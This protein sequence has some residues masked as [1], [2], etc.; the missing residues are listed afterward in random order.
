MIVF[1]AHEMYYD[2]IWYDSKEN[3][4]QWVENLCRWQRHPIETRKKFKPVYYYLLSFSANYTWCLSSEQS[5]SWRQQVWYHFAFEYSRLGFDPWFLNKN[6]CL[7]WRLKTKVTKNK[8]T[9]GLLQFKYPL[10][11]IFLD[12][13]KKSSTHR[14]V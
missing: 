13:W 8:Q 3:N 12:R 5:M 10:F 1:G 6:Q 11:L 9:L 14:V 2:L 7:H 4:L